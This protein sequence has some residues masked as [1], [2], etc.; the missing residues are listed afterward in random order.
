MRIVAWIETKTSVV[1]NVT[2]KLQKVPVSTADLDNVLS[3]KIVSLYQL[4]S[5][6]VGVLAETRRG[7]QIVFV[8][9]IVL[10]SIGLERRVIDESAL[11]ATFQLHARTF[12]L[13]GLSARLMQD[14]GEH[15]HGL[16]RQNCRDLGTVTDRTS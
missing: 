1:S 7:R 4:M 12:R 10:H 8:I 14:I 6:N 5:Q 9:R 16:Q 11:M 13:K 2:N 15:R 3:V